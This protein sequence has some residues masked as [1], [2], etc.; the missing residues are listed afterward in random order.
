[1]NIMH[2]IEMQAKKTN[3]RFCSCCFANFDVF[4]VPSPLFSSNLEGDGTTSPQGNKT[5]EFYD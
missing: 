2:E 3:H 1:M 4:R 5:H